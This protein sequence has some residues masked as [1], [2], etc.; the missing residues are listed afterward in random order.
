M[1]KIKLGIDFGTSKCCITY[2]K[3][4]KLYVINDNDNEFINSIIGIYN[5]TILIGNQIKKDINYDMTIINN[6]KRLIGIDI[7][8]DIAIKL[9]NYY[10]WELSYDKDKKDIIINNYLLSELIIKIFIYLRNLINQQI[11]V[12]FDTILTVPTNFNN[13]QRNYI[14]Y[15]ANYAKLNCIEI[16]NE[17]V[18]AS[19]S[20]LYNF[21]TSNDIKFIV[22]DFGAG[23]L[24]LSLINAYYDDNEW[25]I[26]VLKNNG[27]NL[28]GGIDINILL[29]DWLKN[30]Y[31]DIYND[32]LLKNE[33]INYLIETLKIYL[34]TTD[35]TIINYK[36]L[37]HTIT[38]TINEYYTLLDNHLSK[39][40]LKLYNE[41]SLNDKYDI[42]L[43]GGSSKNKWLYHLFNNQP[44][45][46][47]NKNEIIN[48]NQKNINFMD[49][50]VSLGA[51]DIK[52]YNNKSLYLL[53][54]ISYSI[55]IEQID[56]KMSK[57]IHKNS[58]LPIT[59]TN[60]YDIIYNEDELIEIKIYQGE[61]ELC[62]HNNLI[63]IL[64]LKDINNSKIS[65]TISIDNNNII[66][67]N[68]NQ[69]NKQHTLII[70]Y[71]NINILNQET[72][73]LHYDIFENNIITSYYSIISIYQKI[74]FNLFDNNNNKLDNQ[75]L[76][77]YSNRLINNIQ[78]Y[79]K[80][81]NPLNYININSINNIIKKIN[82][83]FDYQQTE[84]IDIPT[85]Q[86]ILDNIINSLY[87]EFNL[88]TN[89]I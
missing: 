80:Y 10:K 77:H 40:I 47:I 89:Y 58:I 33:N 78:S 84:I 20:Y 37:N 53:N 49:I 38:I 61:N 82:I 39:D 65:I 32:I 16:I 5:N 68:T 63:G 83:P 76:S 23:T 18:A 27:N 59:I 66:N 52:N 41:L 14:L 42:L 25:F 36:I 71:N 85:L 67:I 46:I 81:I 1:N 3:N 86:K 75:T 31:N 8:S 15:C 56:G 79:Y 43:I 19:L 2:H 72:I 9:S 30:N 35:E 87:D 70:D 50:A 55:G 7:N 6:L 22:F 34:S 60:E 26:E 45:T 57:I 13:Y 48:I 54:S 44:I 73:N 62:I 28:L 88:L 17:P 12:D 11:N 21:S 74:I 4:N 69:H 24:D 29:M 64:K 51:I